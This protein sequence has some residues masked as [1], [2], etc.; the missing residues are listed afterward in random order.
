MNDILVSICIP[1]YEMNGVGDKYLEQSFSILEK[2]SYSNFEIVISD[3]SESNS[4][5][6]LCKKWSNRLNINH[7]YNEYNR[8]KSS[9]NI[10]NALKKAKKKSPKL[11]KVKPQSK[12][13]GLVK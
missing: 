3:H 13:K 6:N 8:G 5:E 1:T 12:T 7:F 9:C 4:I 2:Q 10:N 11:I